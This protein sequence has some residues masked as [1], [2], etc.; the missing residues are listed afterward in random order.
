MIDTFSNKNGFVDSYEST[1]FNLKYIYIY[2]SIPIYSYL[3][4]YIYSYIFLFTNF[5]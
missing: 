4:I 1:C 5:D 2:I 3:Y